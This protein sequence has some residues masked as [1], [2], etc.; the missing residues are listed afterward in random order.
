MAIAFAHHCP[1]LPNSYGSSTS[2]MMTTKVTA[3]DKYRSIH[4]YFT[5]PTEEAR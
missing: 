5:F 1:I 4:L 2:T 3:K